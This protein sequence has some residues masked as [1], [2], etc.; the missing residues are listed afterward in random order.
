MSNI[1]DIRKEFEILTNVFTKELADDL[2]AEIN[3]LIKD[4]D[5]SLEEKDVPDDIL[6][7]ILV[8]RDEHSPRPP[9][10]GP[11]G[12]QEYRDVSPPGPPPPH[13]QTAETTSEPPPRDEPYSRAV[14][15]PLREDRG[16]SRE[17]LEESY[18]RIMDQADG[19]F[20][21]GQFPKAR[22]LYIEVLREYSDYSTARERLDD[23]EDYI[24]QRKEVPFDL[25]PIGAGERFGEAQSARRVG[26]YQDALRNIEE[27]I[28]IV[29]EGGIRRWKEGQALKQEL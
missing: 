21:S 2:E 1:A 12:E 26:N 6:L 16:T 22:D 29:G 10:T 4:P 5:I 23:C 11:A 20:F 9:R 27:A 28:Q 19:Y 13:E 14:P 7:D 3:Q 8:L 18:R 25:L 15:L 17:D 24:A